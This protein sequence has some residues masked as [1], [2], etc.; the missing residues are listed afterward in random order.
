M[1]LFAALSTMDQLLLSFLS[2]ISDTANPR[3]FVWNAL[4]GKRPL[5]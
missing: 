1:S 3:A 5:H 2:E 4:M